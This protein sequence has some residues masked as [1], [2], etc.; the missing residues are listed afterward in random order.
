MP[1]VFNYNLQILSAVPFVERKA[2]GDIECL[3]RIARKQ[4]F[5]DAEVKGD[6]L[7]LANTTLQMPAIG[8]DT[9]QASN[10]LIA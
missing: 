1:D 6:C 4:R 3:L 8:P 5:M 2:T 7:G 9:A 10:G